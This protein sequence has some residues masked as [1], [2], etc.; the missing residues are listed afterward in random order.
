MTVVMQSFVYAECHQLS[1]MLNVVMLSVIML[2]VVASLYQAMKLAIEL[3]KEC[4]PIKVLNQ[5]GL[6]ILV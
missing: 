4:N 1:L 5:A 3:I 2:K 6:M